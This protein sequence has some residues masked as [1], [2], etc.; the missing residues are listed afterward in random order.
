MLTAFPDH[1]NVGKVT[2]LMS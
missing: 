1:E 2:F